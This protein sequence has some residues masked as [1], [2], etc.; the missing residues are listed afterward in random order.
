[1]S[2]YL[3]PDAL[4]LLFVQQYLAEQGY[5]T[6]KH[7]MRQL[8]HYQHPRCSC[9]VVLTLDMVLLRAVLANPPGLSGPG[10]RV[11]LAAAHPLAFLFLLGSRAAGASVLHGLQL[12]QLG[13]CTVTNC[14]LVCLRL[15]PQP[16][17]RWSKPAASRTMMTS[18]TG[19]V[20]SWR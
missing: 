20:N 4:A 13:A 9:C 12:L 2:V 18:P 6:G 8:L 10:C 19:A 15:L 16:C 11:D 14:F 17:M 5:N 3:D 7:A 1:M